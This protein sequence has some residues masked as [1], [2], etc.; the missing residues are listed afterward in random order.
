M[1]FYLRK[2]FRAGPVRL[3]LSKKGFG[4]SAGVPGFRIGSGP[5]GNY[6]HAGR[7][8]L[9]Y[10]RN[11]QGNT[12]NNN[13]TSD[14]SGLLN[15]IGVILAALICVRLMMWFAENPFVILIITS[16]TALVFGLIFYKKYSKRKFL[17]TYKRT[18]DEIFLLGS[19]KFDGQML[20]PMKDKLQKC[21]CGQDLDEIEKNI[22]VAV[23]DKVLDDKLI[24]EEEKK[25][26]SDL[27][28][29][30]S[31]SDKFKKQTKIEIINSFYLEAIDDRVITNSEINSLNNIIDGLGIDKS[32]I[33]K[34]MSV[35][36]QIVR[37]QQLSLPLKK[38]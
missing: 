23:L 3:N 6:I 30:V 19:L 9:Y 33:A 2:S 22:Y 4:V 15:V 28:T 25:L 12:R 29:I 35:V 8:G 5:S 17:S 1:G 32:E 7:G 14:Y 16:S 18:L 27:E 10:R 37:M 36:R 21:K 38:N 11:L 24:T 31:V 20:L 26:I 13:S 34:E